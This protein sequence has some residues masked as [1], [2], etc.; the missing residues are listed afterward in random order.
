MTD[1]YD[2][3]HPETGSGNISKATPEWQE[4]LRRAR[5]SYGDGY[6]LHDAYELINQEVAAGIIWNKCPNCG[7]P[8]RLDAEGANGTT[9][10]AACWDEFAADVMGG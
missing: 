8:Y 1:A 2:A 10:S 5:E 6:V 7:C 9:C 3:Q 4:I